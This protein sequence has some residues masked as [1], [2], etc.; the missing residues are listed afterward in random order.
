[1]A[2]LKKG[3]QGPEV[4]ELQQHLRQLGFDAEG[5]FGEATEAAVIAYQKSRGLLPDGLVGP[6]TMKA[7]REN[8]APAPEPADAP[9]ALEV[10]TTLRLSSSRFLQQRF[11]KDLIVLHHTA[12]GSARST[13]NWWESQASR[14]A[15]AYI[16]ERD[17]TIYEV[18]DPRDWAFH[19]GIRGTNGSVDKRSIGIEMASEGGLLKHTDG[20]FY[21]FDQIKDSCR[22]DGGVYDHGA[23]WRSYRHYAAYTAPQMASVTRLVDHLCDTFSI[24]RKTPKDHLAFDKNLYGFTGIV[25]HHH[26]RAD[27]TDL[28]PG[29]DWAALVREAR[30]RKV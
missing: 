9:E 14:I 16:V 20:R 15:T 30:L 22:F 26:V 3:S 10:N 23:K 13:F 24:P 5:T 12:G 2:L 25:G 11:P 28:H 18:F 4:A 1:M 21:S 17:G 6:V 19:L 8:A 7:I 27:K 29:F